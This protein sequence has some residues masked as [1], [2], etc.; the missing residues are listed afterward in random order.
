MGLRDEW[1]TELAKIAGE[2]HQ[3]VGPAWEALFSVLDRR[4]RQGYADDPC[5][6][7]NHV[8]AATRNQT[9][10]HILIEAVGSIGP[11]NVDGAARRAAQLI[12]VLKAER[13]A[14]KGKGDS[15]IDEVLQACD[16]RDVSQDGT[17]A[18]PQWI[19]LIQEELTEMAIEHGCAGYPNG[20][21]KRARLVAIAALCLAAVEAE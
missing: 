17:H 1:A 18:V 4:L 19:G 21:P 10:C 15:F 9:A 2:R 5:N 8:I 16:A 7:A 3:A 14:Q 13:A 11:E 6:D 12:E 20:N